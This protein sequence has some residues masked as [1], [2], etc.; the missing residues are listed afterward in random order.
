MCNADFGEYAPGAVPPRMENKRLHHREV[1]YSPFRASHLRTRLV[2]MTP[3]RE[4]WAFP[5]EAQ[6]PPSPKK[7]KR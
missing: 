2:R 7:V 3:V 6:F 5:Y 4:A 1:Q